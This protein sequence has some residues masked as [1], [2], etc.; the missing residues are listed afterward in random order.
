M[1]LNSIIM[2]TLLT[3]ILCCVTAVGF[4]QQNRTQN[5][6]EFTKIKVY[7]GISAKLIKSD[8]NKVII[9]GAHINAVNIVDKNGTLKLRMDIE[10]TFSGFRTFAEIHY[11][12]ILELIDVNEN[13]KIETQ[14]AV[15]QIDVLVRAQEGGEIKGEFEVQKLNIKAVT[16]G[17]ITATG[18]AKVQTV[19]I[20]TGGR[21]EGDNLKTEQTT[22]DV[23]AGGTAY[24]NASDLVEASVKAG[25]TIRVYGKPKVL[26]KK[27]FIGGRIIEQ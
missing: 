2:R 3:I 10:K 6:K 20:N 26:D 25:G 13:S 11:K 9:T 22:V 23:S 4:S 27:K 16:G 19:T 15:K 17:M 14:G 18:K 21:Y 8:E 5:T 7:D 24:V 12:G 1:F